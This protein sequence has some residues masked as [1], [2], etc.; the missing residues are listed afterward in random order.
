MS[1]PA[2]IQQFLA[3]D[4]QLGRRLEGLAFAEQRPAVAAAL[5]ER[6]RETSL[7]I[8]EVAAVDDHA[9]PVGGGEITLRVYTPPGEPPH[10][11]FFHVHGGGFVNGSIELPYNAA[12]C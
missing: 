2:E 6:A 7:R 4:E 10:P 11:V 9:V 3:W 12:K 1:L 5:A 8:D